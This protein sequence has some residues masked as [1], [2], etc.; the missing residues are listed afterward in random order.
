MTV[1]QRIAY[2]DL[3]RFAKYM[4]H[5]IHLCYIL[6]SLYLQDLHVIE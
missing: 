5:D 6:L 4:A 1:I 3:K 2:V